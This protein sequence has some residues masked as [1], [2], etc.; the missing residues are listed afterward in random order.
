M[1]T[2][3]DA[4]RA[5]D[6]LMSYIQAAGMG[7]QDEVQTIMRLTEKLGLH[8]QSQGMRATS[9]PLGGLSRIPEG[10][11]EITSTPLM[12]GGSGAQR[13]ATMTG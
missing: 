7:S 13:D 11:N 1:P 8:Q 4:R 2:S 12:V 9:T 10:D 6:T 3:E 5:A